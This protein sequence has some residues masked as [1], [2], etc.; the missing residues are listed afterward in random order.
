[1]HPFAPGD[2]TPPHFGQ[3]R[4]SGFVFQRPKHSIEQNVPIM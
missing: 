2:F 1:M 4:V 3:A